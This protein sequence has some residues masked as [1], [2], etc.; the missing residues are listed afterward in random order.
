M[1]GRRHTSCDAAEPA[2][3]Y[4]GPGGG[5]AP[6]HANIAAAAARALAQMMVGQRLTSLRT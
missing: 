2:D 3:Q 5:A 4:V 1:K 6:D